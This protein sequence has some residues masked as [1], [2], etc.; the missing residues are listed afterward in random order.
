MY[1]V[2]MMFGLTLILSQG[3]GN[4]IL[5]ARNKLK[6]RGILLLLLTIC[7][8]ILGATLAKTYGGLGMIIGTVIFMLA[9]RVIITWYYHKK[10][11]LQ[12]F[13]YYKEIF[14]LFF[15][16]FLIILVTNYFTNELSNFSIKYLLIKGFSYTVVYASI[17][18]FILTNSEKLLVNEAINKGKKILLRK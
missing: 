12:M 18:W 7:G 9:E 16:A 11:D 14:P 8:T 5:E 17:F 3:F 13:R 1:V 2:L 10:I 15:T 6:F 4:N